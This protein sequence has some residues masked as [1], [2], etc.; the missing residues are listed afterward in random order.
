MD[1][2]KALHRT[3]TEERERILA[4]I[5]SRRASARSHGGSSVQDA[6]SN[7]GDSEYGDGATDAYEQVFDLTM[8]DKHRFRLAQLEAALARLDAGIYGRC[9]R[10]RQAIGL[11]RL[12]AI[13]ETAYCLD[14]EREVEAQG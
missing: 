10:C 13:P 9:V 5:E 14:C 7:S 2:Y 12:E 3:L 4:A 11:L 6:F 1:R 8:L